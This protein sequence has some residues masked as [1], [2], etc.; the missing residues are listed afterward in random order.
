MGKRI[1]VNLA[2]QVLTAF[3]GDT[4]VF[5]FDCVSGDYAHPTEEVEKNVKG[6]GI[7]KSISGNE[8]RHRVTRKQNPCYSAKYHA[9][10]N[11]AM[12]FTSDGKAIHQGFAVMPLSYLKV[13]EIYGPLIGSHGCVRLAEDNARKLY[14]WTPVGTEVIIRGHASLF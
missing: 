5:V 1:E 14:D 9:Q 4:T 6:K 10:M 13:L 7:V 3:D 8:I 11:Y 12:F 2:R